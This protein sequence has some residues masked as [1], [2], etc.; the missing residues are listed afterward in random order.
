MVGLVNADT[1]TSVTLTSAGAA[2]SATVALSP[3]T[4]VIGGALGTGLG[5]YEITYENGSLT[6]DKAELTISAEDQSKTYGDTVVF[7]TTS[8]SADFSVVGLVNADTVTSV[9][10]TS[11]GAAASAT[12][13]LSP[14][15]IVIGGALGTGLGN[16]E[17]TYENGSLT[18]DKAELTI[19]AEDQSKTYGDTV[20]FD[21]TSP[22]ADFSVVGL[23]NADTVTSVT[24][25][26]AGAAASATVAGSPYII[27]IGGA[28]GSG[29]GNYEITTRTAA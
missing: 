11:A 1:V 24:L 20:V 10:L 27:V 14:Y 26:S 25:T 22:S 5:N 12:V 19:S 2:A 9:T 23:V 21:T 6:V 7:D 8:P 3:Y 28:L 17:I 16:Y 29:L 15:T 4:I 18:V 13:A